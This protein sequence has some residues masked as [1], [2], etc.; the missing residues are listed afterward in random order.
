M[1]ELP[2]AKIIAANLRKEIV[3]KKVVRVSGNFTDHKFTFYSGDPN[4][5]AEYLEGKEVTKV[6]DRNFYVEIEMTDYKL[7]MRD[8]AN[9][10]Y[11]DKL[12]KIPPKSKLMLVF[13]D[14]SC[15]NVTTSMYCMIYVFNKNEGI[16]NK[17]YNMEL[18]GIGPLDADFTTSYFKSLI[19]DST[20]KLSLKAFL[21]TEQRILGI[22]NGVVQDILFNAR[23]RPKRKLNTLSSEEVF[24]LYEAVIATLVEMVVNGGRDSEKNIY[25]VSGGYK[26]VL[27]SKNYK[28]DC[29]VCRGKITKESYLGGSIYYCANCQ[30]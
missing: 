20:L 18:N 28:D 23:M 5:Y 24:V 13:N 27:S 1:I 25:G 16:E 22:G 11:Y 12:D 3:G 2:E 19:N 17:Y 15:L 7:I 8:G 10:R 30:K 26:T 29:P 6:N 9:I 14:G 21:A 4:K